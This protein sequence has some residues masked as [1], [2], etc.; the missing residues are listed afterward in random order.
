MGRGVGGISTRARAAA[1]G[2]GLG[3]SG[4][5]GPAGFPGPDHRDQRPI[6]ARAGRGHQRQDHRSP[7]RSHGLPVHGARLFGRRSRPHALR[8]DDDRRDLSRL[9]SAGGQALVLPSAWAERG[10][11]PHP[12]PLP[13]PDGHGRLGVRRRPDRGPGQSGGH[14]RRCG[15]RAGRTPGAGRSG[16]RP[17]VGAGALGSRLADDVPGWAAGGHTILDAHP[18]PDLD[19]LGRLRPGRRPDG[20]GG[21]SAVLRLPRPE[22]RR[23]GCVRGN[24]RADR[25][26]LEAAVRGGAGVRTLA[27]GVLRLP[28]PAI[29]PGRDD[30]GRRRGERPPQ[31]G[32]RRELRPAWR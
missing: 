31:P 13:G 16:V 3:G 21:G 12:N 22:R 23:H 30:L 6:H 17:C 8:R 25:R 9:S 26:R 29:G 5:L 7:G 18:R 19:A 27:D 24:A 32:R 4:L 15:G 14:G 1:G 28:V 10:G 11:D 20:G 2:V